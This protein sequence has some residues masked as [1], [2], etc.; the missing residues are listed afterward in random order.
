MANPG[1]P[2]TAFGAI[3]AAL[4]L[5]RANGHGPFTVQSSDNLQN[6]GDIVRDTVVSL[7]KLINPELAD[8][9]ET[10]CT[11]PNA[12]V[13]CIVPATGP[14]ELAQARE[15]G[16][17][18]RAPV[19]HESFRQWVIEDRF[20]AG[21]PNWERVG[22]TLTDDVHRFEA[23][24]LR[25]LNGGH[26][27]VANAGELLGIDTISEASTHPLIAAMFRKVQT[28]EVLPQI[29]AVPG[30][31]APEYLALIEQRF[32]NPRI[33]DTTRRVAFDGSSRHPGFLLPS[34]RERLLA[35]APVDG[36][37]LV[38]ALWA[39]MCEGVREGGSAIEPNDPNW[40]ALQKAAEA[41]RHDPSAWLAQTAI[42]DPAI[43]ENEGFRDAFARHHSRICA[44][45]VEA[46]IQAYL[47]D[48]I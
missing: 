45:G 3:V 13:D 10:N 35:N 38:E 31:T 24:K 42:Y 11:F 23:M 46:A 36:L 19:T 41:T 29:E 5:R 1:A 8:W 40:S 20:C 6:N 30:F 18:D 43:A 25:I 22:A 33:V 21:R 14:N 28:E 47:E 15:I 12:M 16:I 26:Q 9:I 7:A 2:T 44:E 4:S 34:I 48:R 27:I 39:R 32:A 17:N 37:A